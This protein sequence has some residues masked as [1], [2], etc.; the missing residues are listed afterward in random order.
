MESGNGG[1]LKS[2]DPLNPAAISYTLQINGAAV[3]LG[4]SGQTVLS[5][6]RRLTD[7]NGDRHEL[8]VIIGQIGNAPA[9]AYEDNLTLTVVS[10][11]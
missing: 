5:R 7:L 9:G 11:N 8:L 3:T 4:R 1:V 10:D 2:A 6:G